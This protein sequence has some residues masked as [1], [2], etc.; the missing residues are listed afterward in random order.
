MT[1]LFLGVCTVLIVLQEYG[2]RMVGQRLMTPAT[3]TS[4]SGF[5]QQDDRFLGRHCQT[6]PDPY[7]RPQWPLSLGLC[8]AGWP[9]SR[10]RP[11]QISKEDPYFDSQLIIVCAPIGHMIIV[12]APIGHL[13]I[14]CAPIG[15]LIIVCAPIGHLIIVCVPI[16][17]LIIVCTP[18]GKETSFNSVKLMT[19]YNTYLWWLLK[20]STWK[21]DY[22]WKKVERYR[23]DALAK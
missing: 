18:I 11:N 22:A 1:S 3:M 5:V 9:L 13:I 20:R 10:K 16:G 6:K 4:L 19:W 8:T 12:C 17:H 7:D 15:H 23:C 2:R 21:G 14:V